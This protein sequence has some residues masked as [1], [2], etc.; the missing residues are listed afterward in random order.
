[1]ALYEFKPNGGE[2]SARLQM[3]EEKFNSGMQFT[4]TPLLEG[5]AKSIVNYDMVDSG[6]A[7]APRTGLQATQMFLPESTSSA[8]TIVAAKEQSIGATETRMQLLTI[9]ARETSGY[10][11]R[12]VTGMENVLAHTVVA[13]NALYDNVTWS[14]YKVSD[15]MTVFCTIPDKA[16]IHDIPINN[17]NLARHPGTYAWNESYYFFDAVNSKVVHTIWDTETEKFIFQSDSPK[18]ITPKEAVSYGYN[19]LLAQ[20]YH[21]AN[22][23]GADGSVI[24]F[25]GMMPYDANDNLCLTPLVNQSLN[26]E[27]F[28]QVPL[29]SRYYITIEWKVSTDSVWSEITHFDTTFTTVGTIHFAFSPPDESIIIRVSAYGYTG[30]TRNTY[31]DSVL[32]VGFTFDRTA[33]G[34]TAN[35][36][37]K[38]YTLTAATG[39]TSWKDRLLIWGIP[40]NQN[41]LF[42]SEVND[43]TY[44]PY[45]NN[46]DTFDEPI[47][48]VVP[49][50]DNALVFTSTKL[51]LLTL[52]AD[53]LSWS[54]KCIQHNL[55]IADWDIHLIQ[56][57]K[58][59]VFFRSGNYYY[60]IVPKSGS[61][62]GELTLAAV[63]KPM[64]Y[65]FDKFRENSIDLI[66][67]MYDR[68]IITCVLKQYYNY[69]DFE[70]V[71]NVYVFQIDDGE[72]I[73]LDLL[74]NTINRC[75]RV[76]TTGSPGILI[77]YKQDMTRKGVLCLANT[78]NSKTVFQLLQYTT[79]SNVDYYNVDYTSTTP[80]TAFE[81]VHIWKNYQYF[82]SGYREHSSNFKKRYRELQFVINNRST[83]ALKFYTDFF[84]D[85]EQRRSHYMYKVVQNVDP[86][87]PEYGSITIE[88]TLGEAIEAAD[89]YGGATIQA[90]LGAPIATPGSTVLGA[91][92]VDADA[93]N[94][95]VD[96]FPNTSFW[97]VHFPVS[98][99]GYTP[100]MVILSRNELPYE[101][102]NTSWIYR[103]MY[104]R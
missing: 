24:Q 57:V 32:A 42:A 54:K 13:N 83:A 10:D 7:L 8:S 52:S 33:Y 6:V 31:T 23:Q 61:T 73:N 22:T 79:N 71:H 91:S 66:K 37:P 53:G 20:P 88:R 29:N 34:S 35:V 30:E 39:M 98:G 21:F 62:T 78:Q 25:L 3:I 103:P 100:R 75:W 67:T 4:N 92:L 68:E 104:S 47:K 5:F 64:Y 85:G 9:Q 41:I 90:V 15:P 43:P 94:L 80:I 76:Y 45:P 74:Y 48:Y 2:R 36:T 14:N 69:L 97:K 40:E 50:L 27:V 102:L 38:T 17:V 99:K 77:P 51:W 18:T 1:M 56:V 44:F 84:I 59:M 101:L 49:F 26:F 86:A 70:D 95:D 28:Y 55:R 81:A 16:E 89:D 93:W 19:M 72:Y 12:V 60:M 11:L 82:D 63:S 96:E 65:F 87:S 58:N 46:A